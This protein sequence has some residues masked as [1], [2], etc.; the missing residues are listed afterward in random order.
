MKKILCTCLVLLLAAC[1]L[2]ACAQEPETEGDAAIPHIGFVY[3]NSNGSGLQTRMYE[4]AIAYAEQIG[5]KLTILDPAGDPTKQITM[6]EDLIQQQVDVLMIWPIDKNAVQQVAK[7]AFEAG[8]PV[9]V[10]SVLSDEAME[11]WVTAYAGEDQAGMGRAL[12]EAVVDYFKDSDKEVIKVVE[13]QATQGTLV[14]QLRN[15]GFVEAIAADPRITIIESHSS[16]GNRETATQIM[17]AYLQ[18]YDDID[19]LFSQGDSF[20]IGAINAIRDAGRAGEIV[21]TGIGHNLESLEYVKSGELTFDIAN[22]PIDLSH[23]MLDIAMKVYNGETVEK[24][25]YAPVILAT[26]D[27]LSTL[28]PPTW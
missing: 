6:V 7:K 23:L 28:T 1:C 24:Y 11:E 4:E 2:L 9:I 25:N 18:K 26:K 3:M 5:A 14:S 19:V 27:N 13:I 20:G 17:E 15:E 22:S 16:D 10:N 12:G 21:T 8:I